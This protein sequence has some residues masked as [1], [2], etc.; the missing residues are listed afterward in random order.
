MR[1]RTILIFSLLTVL[2]WSVG[3]AQ[4]P[5]FLYGKVIDAET[6]EPV[7]FATIRI[8]NKAIG[9]ISNDDGGFAIPMK[10]KEIGEILEITSMGFREQKILISELTSE[11]I[12]IIMLFPKA[13]ELQEVE[14]AAKKRRKLSA[15]EIVRKAITA[16]PANYPLY[17]FA[18]VGYYRDYQKK[19]SQYIN[20]NE[21]ILGVF[22]EGFDT[23]DNESTSIRI[24]DYRENMDF[25]RDTIAQKPY[26]YKS[27]L[28]VI[29]NAFLWNYGGN[30][31]TILRIHDALR[32]YD[33]DSYSFVH[34]L[35]YDFVENHSFSREKNTYLADE[36]LYNI[37]FRKQGPRHYGYGTLYI[38]QR[39]FSIYKME[40]AVYDRL[41]TIP[42][43]N[44]NKNETEEQLI[45]EVITEYQ[46]VNNKMF[47]NYISFNN[48]FRLMEPPKFKI[49][50]MSLD[51]NKL[52]F[53]VIFNKEPERR[54]AV[55]TRF[56]SLKY[57]GKRIK[58][59][60]IEMEKKR[61]YLYPKFR[62]V[63]ESS[64]F[65]KELNSYR[66]KDDMIDL[67]LFSFEV[68]SIID[69]EGNEINTP[70]YGNFNQ[71]R[72][73]F[74]QQVKPYATGPEDSLYMTKDKPIFENQP[75]V[76]PD[77]FSELWMNTPLK[78]IDN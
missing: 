54:S 47:L 51:L 27:G 67:K 41:K 57:K 38:S 31:F 40:Y 7:S 28:K 45:F 77:D 30:E 44:G 63:A 62:T 52:C 13:I 15:I 22:D 70:T 56:Y 36:P 59:E 65:F 49:E 1:L 78:T 34:R 39:D 58:L 64:S 43:N 68:K 11:Q 12:N 4:Q 55:I 29:D 5:E 18:T 6:K 60:E 16:V 71:F 74:V 21:A 2:A 25:Q 3:C 26:N 66:N 20:L 69:E 33:M 37:S 76:K 19:E 46:R 35:K 24:Y 32:N 50:E 75:I 8:Q 61:A 48:T 9:V 72:E 42:G 73:F 17:S 53:V 14:V 10:F 23:S